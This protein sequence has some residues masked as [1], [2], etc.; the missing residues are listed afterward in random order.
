MTR[1]TA[2]SGAILVLPATTAGQQGP[3]AAWLSTAGWAGSARRV[4]GASWIVTP[5]GILAIEAV[6]RRATEALHSPP[7]PSSA[8]RRR[9]PV[10][11]KT[12]SKDA[13][14]WWRARR[15]TIEANGPWRD[16]DIAFVWQRHE[17]FHLAGHD[18]ASRLNVPSVLFVPACLVAQAREWGRVAERHGESLSFTRADVVAAGSDGVA[19]HIARLGVDENRIVITPSGVDLDLFRDPSDGRTQRSAL[20]LNGRFVVG[21]VGSFRGFHALDQAIDAVAE[22]PE[23][24]LLLVGD[25]PERRRA[26]DRASAAGVHVVSTGTVSHDSVPGLLAAMDVALVLAAPGQP[27]H[28]SPLKLAEYLASGVAVVAPRSGDIPG[29]LTDGVDALLYDPGDSRQLAGCLRRLRDR[30]AER[31]RLADAG[32]TAAFERWSWDRSVEK[33][34]GAVDRVSGRLHAT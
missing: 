24:T 31:L 18:L 3:V 32:R 1:A 23:A 5:H 25:G 29:Q 30:P 22:V 21:W 14:E 15:F 27:F 28:Y 2:G 20:S 10:I 33:V 7:R 34:V 19:A 11:A 16:R 12:A 13:R 4:L 17:L 8:W 26:E 6:R 9:V